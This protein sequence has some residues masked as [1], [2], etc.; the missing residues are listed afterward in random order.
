MDEGLPISYEMLHEGVPVLS[1]EG[2][3]V[4]TV[5]AVLSAE[6][7]DIFHGLLINTPEHGVRFVEAASIASL[8]EHGVDLRID[9]AAAS[10]LPPPEHKAPVFDED[11]SHQQSWRHWVNKLTG[12]GDW[13]RER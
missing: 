8:H 9:K 10:A 12:R 7:E 6:S 5:G 13:D 2:K 1:S 11:P 4:G 3:Q